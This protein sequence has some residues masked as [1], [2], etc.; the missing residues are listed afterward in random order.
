MVR[1]RRGRKRIEPVLVERQVE[2]PVPL[3][4]AGRETAALE[5]FATLRAA[6]KGRVDLADDRRAALGASQ[7]EARIE[8]GTSHPSTA[9]CRPYQD[10][11]ERDVRVVEDRQDHLV[12]AEDLAVFQCRKR[13]LLM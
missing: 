9:R 2:E 7:L 4:D 11:H 3:D 6:P 8:Q 1:G 13:M 10:L 5:E 12:G